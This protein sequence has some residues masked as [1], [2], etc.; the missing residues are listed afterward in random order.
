MHSKSSTRTVACLAALAVIAG[1]VSGCADRE[2]RSTAP[3]ETAVAPIQVAESSEGVVVAAHPLAAAAGARML[4]LGGNAADA[5]AA[6]AFALAVVEPTMSG[7]GGRVQILVRRPGGQFHAIDGTTQAPLAYDDETAPRASFG[8]AVVGIPGQVAGVLRLQGEHGRL[9][10]ADVLAP[11]IALA[12]GGFELL[13]GEAGRMLNVQ[14]QLAQSEG[15][16]R[17]F[18]KPDGS[19]YEAGELFIQ[20]DLATTLRTI[21][22]RGAQAFYD[23]TIAEQIAMD[24]ELN[25]GFVTLDDL[26]SYRAED[27]RVVRGSYRGHD[28][29]GT[30]RPAGGGTT[31]EALHILEN[32]PVTNDEEDW[33]FLVG[34]ALL[35][36]LEDRYSPVPPEEE[37]TALITSKEWAA[38]RA[39]AV[40]LPTPAGVAAGTPPDG[41]A[42]AAGR[43]AWPRV[44]GGWSSVSD[45]DEHTSH[46][47]AADRDGMVVA[48]TQS[49]GPAG[50]SRVATQGL[51]FLYAAT[52]GGY[53][54]PMQPGQ[55]AAS[56]MAP[57]VV[58]RDGEVAY[59]MGAAGGV[60]IISS[61][62]EV[63]S[64]LVDHGLTL[65]DA[66]TRARFFPGF[67]VR[68]ENGPWEF[69]LNV[70]ASWDSTDIR[71]LGVTA[72]FVDREGAFGR[73][74]AIAYDVE[75]GIW[76]G[77]AD[78]DWEGAAAVPS[79]STDS[80][81]RR[82]GLE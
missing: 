39:R 65:P 81:V 49:L 38:E 70:Q 26:A 16:K 12:A 21:A 42:I 66:I 9:P 50:G 13:P 52:L 29:V 62:V 2:P 80:R 53:L 78:P 55:R 22:D 37:N 43:A 71:G 36:A 33:A 73:L 7:L 8:Y 32:L 74:H 6:A 61:V 76:Q 15:A 68:R 46:L 51:G 1:F 24:M 34:Q 69:E 30:D 25:E 4:E 31:I 14:D 59:V 27:V 3:A 63:T 82:A 44:S 72:R 19:T 57:F 11:A 35:L 41:A 67:G 58:L 47:S 48:L 10:R 64:R 18:L 56:S 20:A 77:V 79:G 75:Q 28:L 54:G 60:R 5:A 45:E 17:Y 23:G 40:R